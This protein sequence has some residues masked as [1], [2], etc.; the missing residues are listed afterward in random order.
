VLSG[1]GSGRSATMGQASA[2][3]QVLLAVGVEDPRETSI[4]D[5]SDPHG[6]MGPVAD[7]LS[8]FLPPPGQDIA[9]G[10]VRANL[11]FRQYV[12]KALLRIG[13]GQRALDDIRRTWGYMLEHGATTWWERMPMKPGASRCHVW[14][15]HPTAF[16]SRHVLG[17][18]PIEPGWRRFGLD[19]QSFDLTHAEGK[20][21]TPHG[22]I[23][24]SW[25]M[26]AQHVREFHLVVPKGAEAYVTIDRSELPRM[27][28]EGTHHWVEND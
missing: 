2:T 5:H 19:S 27:L 1:R 28:K 11:F 10:P 3:G 15:A 13:L 16:L 4:H 18:Y 26:N 17:L 9:T 12:H 20:V 8:N 6:G 25:K 14:S 22:A 24:V 7:V 21:P 23:E